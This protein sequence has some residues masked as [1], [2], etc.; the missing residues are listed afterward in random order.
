MN[1]LPGKDTQRDGVSTINTTQG[2]TAYFAFQ[3][4]DIVIFL[5]RLQWVHSSCSQVFVT[6]DNSASQWSTT[7]R[8]ISTQ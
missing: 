8:F 2:L 6:V 3:R 5:P 1:I 4:I 7:T